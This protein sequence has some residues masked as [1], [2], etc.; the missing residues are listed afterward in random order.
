MDAQVAAVAG[1][2]GPAQLDRLVAETIKRFELADPDPTADPEDGYLHLDPRHAT[3]HDEDVDF[4]GTM[5]FEGVLDIADA[6]DLGHAVSA[7]AAVQK[8]L[9]STE[10]LDVR[11]AKALGNLAR[12]QTALDLSS[13]VVE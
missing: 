8:A 12:T 11:R 13:Q 7:D 3:L 2:I 10:S 9:G 5:R 4:G 6:L 1:R